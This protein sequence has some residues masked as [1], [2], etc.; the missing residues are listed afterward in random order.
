MGRVRGDL[1]SRRWE[2]RILQI[3][4]GLWIVASAF[5]WPHAKPQ[6]V[7]LVAGGVLVVVTTVIAGIFDQLRALVGM[8]GLWTLIA[9]LTTPG[10]GIATVLSTVYSV[11]LLMALCMLPYSEAKLVQR[12]GEERRWVI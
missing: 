4:I 6:T 8:A 3:V 12:F 1:V 9:V 10:G 5:I 7:A 11:V 2:A